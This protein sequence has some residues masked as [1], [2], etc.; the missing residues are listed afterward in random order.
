M[1]V[2]E[3]RTAFNQAAGWLEQEGYRMERASSPDLRSAFDMDIP[4]H[5]AR[6]PRKCQRM[7]GSSV[8]KTQ[9][10]GHS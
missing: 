8:E 7:I 2:P 3:V 5:S 9:E 1:M 4:T 6:R 10:A